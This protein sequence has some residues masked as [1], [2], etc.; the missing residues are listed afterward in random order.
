[1]A[2]QFSAD[3]TGDGI[4]SPVFIVGSPRSGT[5]ILVSTLFAGG[6]QGF[7]EGN[8]LSLLR[9]F[10][11][12]L[13]RHFNTFGQKN[14]KV[15]AACIDKA[16]LKRDLFAVLKRHVE[17][18]NPRD[19]WLDKTG[20]P[21][22]M[23]AIPDLMLLWPA[24]RFVFAKR[25]AIENI[26]SRLK[27]FPGHNFEY[28]CRDWVANMATWRAMRDRPGLHGIEIDQQDLIEDPVAAVDRLGAFLKLPDGVYPRMIATLR[29][30]RPQQTDSGSAARRLSLDGTG[31]STEQKTIF[32]TIC[33]EEM[34]MYGYRF[35]ETYR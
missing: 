2:V 25:R 22:I 14:E 21:Q 32:E 10:D 13:D 23:E 29:N 28:H 30:D 34:R 5:S 19:P 24:A 35:D 17:A 16:G 12:F 8:F 33:G 26:V 4:G 27:K 9:T 18:L 20:N 31:W 6:Y 1:M 7:R 15:M 3:D 11:I